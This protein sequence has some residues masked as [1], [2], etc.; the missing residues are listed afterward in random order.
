MTPSAL[1][2]QNQK[3]TVVQVRSVKVEHEPDGSAIAITSN[4]TL[5]PAITKLDGPP[6]LVIDLPDTLNTVRR[7]IGAEGNDIRGVRINQYQQA[8]PVTRVVVDLVE[9]RSYTWEMV[10]DRLVVHLRPITFADQPPPEQANPS[11]VAT[12]GVQPLGATSNG[13]GNLAV[14]LAGNRIAPGSSITAGADTAILS[15]TRGGQVH[16]CPGTTISVTTSQ[17][18]GELML[19]MSTGSLEAHYQIPAS[20]DSIVTPDFRIELPGPGAFD[21][22]VSADSK[23]NTCIRALPGNQSSAIVSELIG[24]GVY[25][26]K[27][28]EQVVFREGQLAK[29]DSNVP[30]DCGCPSQR[31][32]VLRAEAEV[33]NSVSQTMSVSPET[34]RQGNDPETA[35]REMAELRDVIPQEVASRPPETQ[36]APTAGSKPTHIFISAPLVFRASD[37]PPAPV[38]DAK[39]LPPVSRRAALQEPSVTPPGPKPP[40]NSRAQGGPNELTKERESKGFF[41]SIKHFLSKIFG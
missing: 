20:A 23:G 32:P 13:T 1:E 33:P 11:P 14:V 18:G 19:G 35:E 30:A 5:V 21:Y 12:E 41:G 15:L 2:N 40:V 8:P 34:A 25:N 17:S 22:A 7:A 3:T 38:R 24:D 4:G 31:E 39:Q 9:P 6:R 28:D 27:A 36:P 26:L 37:P 29:H 10:R 16:V